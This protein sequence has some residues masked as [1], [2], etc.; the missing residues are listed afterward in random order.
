MSA[1]ET[2][3]E[4]EDAGK[5]IA[6]AVET[7]KEAMKAQKVGEAKGPIESAPPAPSAPPPLQ[8]FIAAPGVNPMPGWRVGLVWQGDREG[9]L[10]AHNRPMKVI[11]VDLKS[12]KIVIKPIGEQEMQKIQSN[13]TAPK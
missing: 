13:T 2:P 9:R 10:V 8:I 12:G 5:W 11:K 6:K 4:A 7:I 3:A 1:D